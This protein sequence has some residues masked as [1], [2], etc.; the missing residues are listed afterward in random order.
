MDVHMT[1]MNRNIK[2]RPG[3]CVKISTPSSVVGMKETRRLLSLLRTNPKMRPYPKTF[4]LAEK[5]FKSPGK[6]QLQIATPPCVYSIFVIMDV[7]SADVIDLVGLIVLENNLLT[8][9]AVSNSLV[10]KETVN[11]DGGDIYMTDDSN[12]PLNLADGHV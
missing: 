7:V 4:I 10:K 11:L 5:M 12:F 2:I 6:F 1:Y 9:H 3:V 8:L